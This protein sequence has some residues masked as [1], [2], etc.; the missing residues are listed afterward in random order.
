MLKIASHSAASSRGES[1]Q[2]A[3]WASSGSAFVRVRLYTV[4]ANPAR[5]RFAHMLDPITPVPI[6]PMR[7]VAGETSGMGAVSVIIRYCIRVAVG[8]L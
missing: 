1:A 8:R 3:P 7:Y 2:R 5:I 6:Q 4:A